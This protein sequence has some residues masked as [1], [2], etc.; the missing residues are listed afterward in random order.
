M[1]HST[2][3]G[4]AIKSGAWK[5]RADNPPTARK[6]NAPK[7]DESLDK[8]PLKGQERRE[9]ERRVLE[10]PEI[11]GP[12]HHAVT[13]LLDDFHR[14]KADSYPG[15]YPIHRRARVSERTVAR[16]IV[17]LRLAGVIAVFQDLS[18][19]WRRRIVF[20]DHPHAPEILR[21]LRSKRHLKE[22]TDGP[23]TNRCNPDT[24]SVP[25]TCSHDKLGTCHHDN[26][27]P[28]HLRKIETKIIAEKRDTSTV[29]AAP[30]LCNVLS[31]EAKEE[32]SSNS[33]SS[34][35]GAGENAPQKTKSDDDSFS[36]DQ[37]R[38]E[39]RPESRPRQ[40][41]Q[42][43]SRIIPPEIVQ[44]IRELLGD[45]VASEVDRDQAQFHAACQGNFDALVG[46]ARAT[47]GQRDGGVD[48]PVGYLVKLAKN[49]AATAIP[50]K[51]RQDIV[52]PID[53]AKDPEL[54]KKAREWIR[55]CIAKCDQE[56]YEKGLVRCQIF[57]WIVGLN[58]KKMDGTSVDGEGEDGKL[59]KM[60]MSVWLEQEIAA[61]DYKTTEMHLDPD[62]ESTV[63]A[64]MR[65]DVAK[66]KETSDC[67]WTVWAPIDEKICSVE[68]K[69]GPSTRFA[70]R[71][72]LQEILVEFGFP[73]E[74]PRRPSK[75]SMRSRLSESIAKT[76]P[77]PTPQ[78]RE[79]LVA[80]PAQSAATPMD[81]LPFPAITESFASTA[82]SC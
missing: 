29:D 43:E 37:E 36:H 79:P 74:R 39:T 30:L 23:K 64:K 75:G 35:K 80:P 68:Y 2:G 26:L 18:T 54:E 77:P 10:R 38:I 73:D 56:G 9:F 13:I 48:N 50:E 62:W 57:S 21:E 58:R 66:A 65:D 22:V 20:I 14:G 78:I 52:V 47:K 27:S 63:R 55:A 28:S 46:A 59:V 8:N 51:W 82:A 67:H 24:R 42:T 3:S 49:Y 15:N 25:D 7:A 71:R 41:T 61:F 33:F 44:K 32:S 40:S 60:M 1:P 81:I 34:A 70:M 72:W 76:T 45:P 5:I 31:L 17:L 12:L 6:S 16:W 4:P 69:Y 19:K 11:K 53:P